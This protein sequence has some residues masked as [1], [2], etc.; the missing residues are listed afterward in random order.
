MKSECKGTWTIA[1]DGL[2]HWED[3]TWYFDDNEEALY[4]SEGGNFAEWE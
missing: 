4:N 3:K 2:E 1:K